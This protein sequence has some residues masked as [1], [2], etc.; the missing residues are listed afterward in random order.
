MAVLT[1]SMVKKHEAYMNLIIKRMNREFKVYQE[2]RDRNKKN[3]Q[4]FSHYDYYIYHINIFD[5]DNSQVRMWYITC[6]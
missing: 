3:C 2:T 6:S 5:R 4:I 1:R